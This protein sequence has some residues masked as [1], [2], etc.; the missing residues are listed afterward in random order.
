MI[1]N[2]QFVFLPVSGGNTLSAGYPKLLKN[3][4]HFIAFKLEKIN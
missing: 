4:D 2:E 1:D 3:S